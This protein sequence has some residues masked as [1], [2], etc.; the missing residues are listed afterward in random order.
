MPELSI[1]IPC[2]NEEHY[3]GRL[4]DCLGK[5]TFRDFQII[6]VDSHSTDGTATVVRRRMRK[7]RRISLL[8]SPRKGVS[9]ARNA[10]AWKAQAERLLFMDADVTIGSDFLKK[11]MGELEERGLQVSGC[12][13]VPDSRKLFD[14]LGHH[15]LNGWFQAMQYVWPHMVGQCIFSTRAIHRKLKGFDSTILF[16]EDN[17]YVNRASTLARFR[18]LR[19]VRVIS[20][21]RRFE[22]EN[23]IVLGM[24]YALCPFYRLIFGEIRTNI[25]NYRMDIPKRKKQ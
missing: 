3:I 13:L 23:S 5:Q 17:D 20:S 15:L 22:S 21:T 19:S 25:F 1:I 12:C 7:D 6:V 18:I 4:L 10:G 11:A 2:L 24:K 16:A 9:D 8:R 14:R